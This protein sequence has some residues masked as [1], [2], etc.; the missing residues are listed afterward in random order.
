[1]LYNAFMDYYGILDVG[2]N[3]D[4]QE[5]KKAYRKKIKEYHPDVYAGDKSFAEEKTKELNEAYSVLKDP[6]R[7]G[8][9]DR[10][11]V[12]MNLYEA[13]EVF[14]VD[15]TVQNIKGMCAGIL[16][17]AFA[18]FGLPFLFGKLFTLPG[19]GG[20]LYVVMEYPQGSM[21]GMS[22][23]SALFARIFAP[24]VMY[25]IDYGEKLWAGKAV[26]VLLCVYLAVY[27][28]KDTLQ[29]GLYVW[30]IATVL[31]HAVLAGKLWRM[32]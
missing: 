23:V 4:V 1:M 28:A 32:K 3:A 17:Y 25:M 16:V 21:L 5:I 13:E 6:A 26:Y 11:L 30:T 14:E 10:E 18:L 7:R 31:V 19:I 12:R 27:L 24:F 8:A 15:S 20:W 9:Y 29:Y 2:I 22:L